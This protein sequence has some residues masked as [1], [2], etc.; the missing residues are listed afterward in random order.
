VAAVA[1]SAAKAMAARISRHS[2]LAKI[3]ASGSRSLSGC[4]DH[5]LAPRIFQSLRGSPRC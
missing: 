2:V 1:D 5:R 4:V 3:M